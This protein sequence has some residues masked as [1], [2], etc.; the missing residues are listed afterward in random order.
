MHS[1]F[2]RIIF[3]L[4]F[5][6]I[7]VGATVGVARAAEI[8]GD[9]TYT[10]CAYGVACPATPSP[11]PVD[12][13]SPTPAPSV[14]TSPTPSITPIATLKPSDGG[15]GGGT[16]GGASPEQDQKENTS[17]G[18]YIVDSGFGHFV[19]NSPWVIPI[20]FFILLLIMAL[21]LAIQAGL[22]HRNIIRLRR[23]LLRLEELQKSIRTFLQL[24]QHYLRTPLA[25]IN[26]ALELMVS[27]HEPRAEI[28]LELMQTLS[29][30]TGKLVD[31]VVVSLQRP[32]EVEARLA[33]VRSTLT[34]TLK[35][36]LF[37]VPV[38]TVAILTV[39]YNILTFALIQID[40]N[41]QLLIL[42]LAV[43]FAAIIVLLNSVGYYRRTRE[44]KIV[45]EQLSREFDAL[46]HTRQS[47]IH[48]LTT[49][50]QADYDLIGPTISQLP[51]S[52]DSYL[53]MSGYESIGRLLHKLSI[54]EQ[55]QQP[56][57][58]TGG[59]VASFDLWEQMQEIVRRVG[60][61]YPDHKIDLNLDKMTIHT[62]NGFVGLTDFVLAAVVQNAALYATTATPVMVKVETTATDVLVTVTNAN[63]TVKSAAVEALFEPF[64]RLNDV[65][66]FNPSGAGISL[67][68]S[69]VIMRSLGGDISLTVPQAGTVSC[70]V[71]IPLQLHIS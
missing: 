36:R 9:G 62:V 54:V 22:E 38:V 25:T 50:L 14:T 43:T 3:G 2:V 47:A 55:L 52:H 15:K 42:E 45:V 26:L 49:T 27:R 44:R 17:I 34:T 8:Y 21:I 1:R 12:G 37:W 46:S 68:V 71:R 61:A 31:E 23:S 48:G 39:L 41:A 40:F 69:R 35:S 70:C 51:E 60:N 58:L 56:D 24:A 11:T 16:S 19:E 63:D 20:L 4:T 28:T 32:P 64:S 66:D 10:E 53:V 29:H 30:D 18:S 33:H 7:L 5:V 57:A 65:L 59:S 6:T 67:Y 13:G